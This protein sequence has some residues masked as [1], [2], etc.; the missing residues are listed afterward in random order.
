MK[1]TRVFLFSFLSLL[2]LIFITFGFHFRINQTA[3]MSSG[4]YLKVKTPLTHD[5]LVEV[6]LPEKLSQL[7]LAR[8]Y[9]RVG[10]CPDGVEPI[11]KKVVGIAGDTID[12]RANYVAING[13]LL[14]HSV[15][16]LNDGNG[17][18]L[19]AIARGQKTLGA[20]ELWLYGDKSIRSWDSRY[21]GAIDK[22]YVVSVLKPIFLWR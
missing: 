22:R 11:F 20:A 2:V 3:S 21:Y 15:T 17:H 18:P 1:T 14:P 5:S 6:C 8:H 10:I 12:V 9:L 4:L 7:G 19:P 13:I 16:F